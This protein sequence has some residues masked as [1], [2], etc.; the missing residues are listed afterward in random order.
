MDTTENRL[1]VSQRSR[2]CGE[3]RF[4]FGVGDYIAIT[5]TMLERA[6]RELRLHPDHQLSYYDAV[7]VTPTGEELD[8]EINILTSKPKGH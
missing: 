3:I 4:T 5:P 7:L 2:V 8:F 1:T 6:E